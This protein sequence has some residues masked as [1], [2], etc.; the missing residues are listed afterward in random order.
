MT[1]Q[2]FSRDVGYVYVACVGGRER[3]REREGFVYKPAV[4]RGKPS[5]MF[6]LT[7]HEPLAKLLHKFG[8]RVCACVY[9]W[10]T[11][12]KAWF[13]MYICYPLKQRFMKTVAARQSDKLR[14]RQ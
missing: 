3:E 11:E 10:I 7:C 8:E 2:M 4:T 1:D 5:D 12:V 9:M 13:L 14:K 6:K